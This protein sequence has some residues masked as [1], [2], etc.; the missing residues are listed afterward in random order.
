MTSVRGAAPRLSRRGLFRGAP[1]VA[2][3]WVGADCLAAGGVMCRSCGDVCPEGAITFPPLLG[4]V[5]QP[6]LDAG[7]CTSCGE[8]VVACPVGALAM[9]R[10][11][12]KSPTVAG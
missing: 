3:P 7:R 6:L 2:R 8:C 11:P 10:M 12:A 9:D 1:G 4:R 5:A